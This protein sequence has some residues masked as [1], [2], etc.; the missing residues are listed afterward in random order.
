M[1]ALSSISSIQQLPTTK[2]SALRLN[3]NQE[4]VVR[5]AKDVN[6]IALTGF[7]SVVNAALKT[8][9]GNQN[10]VP[11]SAVMDATVERCCYGKIIPQTMAQEMTQD[12]IMD[13]F[14]NPNV[15]LF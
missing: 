4:E 2:V 3:L 5:V 6:E 8:V 7:I 9:V 1:S 12:A 14:S 15:N 10:I 13:M 11:D